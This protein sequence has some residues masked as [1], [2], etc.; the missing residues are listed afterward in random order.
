MRDIDVTSRIRPLDMYPYDSYK[1]ILKGK[2][3]LPAYRALYLDKI[4]EANESIYDER[5]AYFTKLVDDFRNIRESED[6]VPESLEE[7]MR[8]Y[9]KYGFQWLKTLSRF[10]FGGILADEMGLGKTIQALLWWSAR[11]P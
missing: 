1:V 7:I 11:R 6:K 5:D 10:G 8:P 9:Q 2:M 3:H 4:L